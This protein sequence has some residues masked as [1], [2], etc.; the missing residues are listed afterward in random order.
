MSIQALKNWERSI[1]RQF[2]SRRQR[3]GVS[4]ESAVTALKPVD[5]GALGRTRSRRAHAD[6]SGAR[7]AQRTMPG[8][9]CN[10]ARLIVWLVGE[11]FRTTQ[12][13]ANGAGNFSPSGCIA[14]SSLHRQAHCNLGRRA[15][16]WGTKCRQRWPPKL[17]VSEDRMVLSFSGD[18]GFQMTGNELA[19]AVQHQLPIICLRGQ[20]RALWHDPNAPGT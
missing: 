3:W 12:F 13:I 4:C 9:H 8:T 14:S 7:R 10:S 17:R 6:Y 15:A 1:S 11:P 18:G 16:Q 2:R 20:Q 19:T 5:G